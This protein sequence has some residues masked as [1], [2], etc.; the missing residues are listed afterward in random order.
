LE[1]SR[2]MITVFDFGQIVDILDLCAITVLFH[3]LNPTAATTSCGS[4]EYS[5]FLG[6]L[7]ILSCLLYS[8]GVGTGN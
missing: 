2:D 4:P 7:G 5:E 8:G 3:V 1:F 6:L